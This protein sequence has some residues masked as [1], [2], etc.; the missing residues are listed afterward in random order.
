MNLVALIK[1]LGVFTLAHSMVWFQ[2]NGQFFSDWFKN[3]M[4][5]TVL[6]GIPISYLYIV[7]TRLVVEGF[8]GLLWPGRLVSFAVGII[9]FSIFTSLIM[10]EGIT[11]KT[12]ISLI[13]ALSLVLIQIFW[14]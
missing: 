3:N 5:V 6:F 7:G 4:L 2:L 8:D 11:T 14:K 13:L 12:G 9:T 1:G 10:S